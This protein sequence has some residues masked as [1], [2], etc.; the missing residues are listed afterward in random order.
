MSTDNLASILIESP[1]ARND[2]MAVFS[3]ESALDKLNKAKAL[4]MAYWQGG[5]VATNAQMSEYFEVSIDAIESAVRRNK[6]ELVS[7][8]LKVLKGKDLKGVSALLTETSKAPSLTIW[9]P[10]AALRLAML[11]RDS[12][13]AKQ[14]R[15]MILDLV[16]IIPKQTEA[17][18]ELELRLALANAEKDAA[19]AQKTLL[20]TRKAISSMYEPT[21]SALIFGAQVVQIESVVEKVIDV[22]SNRTFDGIG[23]QEI[24]KRLGFGKN[25]KSCWAWL[26]SI[27]YGKDSDSW[28]LQLSAIEHHKLKRDA[29]SQ[30][31]DKWNCG[32][33]QRFIGEG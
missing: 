3:H 21:M 9:T 22:A 29:M 13:I 18:R 12:E 7:D 5:N 20:E 15:T 11:L 23:I 31:M 32:D 16:E 28:E 6:D 17:I 30:I 33:R 26:E 10:R 4:V 24:A 27:G 14:V 25:T 8:G 2:K 1:S 19:I